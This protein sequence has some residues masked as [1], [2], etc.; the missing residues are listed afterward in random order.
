MAKLEVSNTLA[1]VIGLTVLI[2]LVH[3]LIYSVR[4]AGVR[5]ERLATAYSLFNLIFLIASTANTVQAPLLS[6]L[7]EK[8]INRGLAAVPPRAPAEVLL[9]SPV[10]REEL[11]V[12]DHNIRLVI[13]AAT[14]GTILGGLLIPAFVRIFSRGILLFEEVGSVPRLILFSLSPRRLYR[15]IKT[16]R[17][18]APEALRRA[19]RQRTSIPKGFLLLNVLITG[20][21]TTGVL[22]ALYAGALFP[23]YRATA[24]LLSPIVNGI[25]TL[26]AATVV[27]PTAAMLTDQALRGK[28]DERDIRQMVTHLAVTRFLGTLLAQVLFL[29][30]AQIVRYV[31]AFIV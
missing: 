27:D 13:L 22:S 21:Y 6:S 16:V 20:I 7:V 19:I 3:T 23:Y 9:A 25:A 8:A 28:R 17:P 29:P 11:A 10:Y 14:L 15:T 24:T 5:T 1:I 4:L 18:A 2:H 26:L 12:L 30:A 31:A